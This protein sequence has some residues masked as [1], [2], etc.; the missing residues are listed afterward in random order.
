MLPYMAKKKKKR[1]RKVCAGGPLWSMI[2]DL[3]VGK[4]HSGL[5]KWALNA[6]MCIATKGVRKRFHRE[7]A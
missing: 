1:K 5:S 6:I 4:N 7:K 2:K 3:E